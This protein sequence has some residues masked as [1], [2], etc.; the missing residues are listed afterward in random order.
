MNLTRSEVH[1]VADPSRVIARPFF[2]GG[3][4]RIRSIVGRILAIPEEAILE[5]LSGI[6]RDFSSRH[7]NFL[8]IL[9]DHFEM[10]TK[11]VAITEPLS[12]ERC[13]LI[14]AY[15]TNEYSLEAA[16]L[17]NP[18]MVIHPDQRGVEEGSAR[19]VLSLR[20]CGEG[21]ISSIEFRD[22]I[23]DREGRV[24][25]SDH[26]RFC[27]TGRPQED[28]LFDQ[29]TFVCK[30]T[31]MESYTPTAER[32]LESLPDPF[33]WSELRQAIIEQ[34]QVLGSLHDFA[35]TVELM[36]W[37]AQS[38]YRVSF[39]AD[40][41]ISER[42]IFPVTENESRGIEDARFVKFTEEDGR[43]IYFGTYT[44]YNGHRV[45]PQLIETPDFRSFKV[46]TLTGRCVQNKGMALFP[47][48]IG[49]RFATISRIDGESLYIMYFQVKRRVGRLLVAGS[50]IDNCQAIQ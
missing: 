45:L 3:A 34:R 25:L 9:W 8:P 48:R 28:S 36:Q 23:V 4:E 39:P 2:P 21:H 37:V 24:T 33:T 47:R 18:S 19:F 22:G 27:Q 16:A 41:E 1:L 49:G 43:S 11:Y 12:E 30:L 14:G 26:T 31:E 44:A 15:F 7:R 50:G 32:I 38:N 35:Q 13:L 20:A 5:Q 42:V 40:S 17:F 46:S 6:L 29:P 10:A